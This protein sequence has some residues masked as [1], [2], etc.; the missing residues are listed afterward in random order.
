MFKFLP[1]IGKL[2]PETCKHNSMFHRKR[3]IK[4]HSVYHPELRES[5]LEN[6]VALPV[7]HNLPSRES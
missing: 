2:P 6:Y 3:N 1:P 4:K 7:T 5:G